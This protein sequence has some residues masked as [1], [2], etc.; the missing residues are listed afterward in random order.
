MWIREFPL[1]QPIFVGNHKPHIDRIKEYR[2]KIPDIGIDEFI[3][4]KMSEKKKF[5]E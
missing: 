4:V 5:K 1:I 2:N 3:R